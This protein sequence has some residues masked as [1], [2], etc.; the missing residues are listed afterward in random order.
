MESEGSL[1]P[2][3]WASTRSCPN[4]YESSPHLR[5]LFPWH[6]NLPWPHYLSDV[7]TGARRFWWFSGDVT[8][9]CGVRG[10]LVTIDGEQYL[11]VRH[12]IM[13]PEVGDLELYV[14]DLFTGSDELSEYRQLP[15]P[16]SLSM[17]CPPLLV[18]LICVHFLFILV[19][20]PLPPL[21]LF[22]SSFYSSALFLLIYLYFLPA[23]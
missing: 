5:T 19:L 13:L 23:P 11:K 8:A 10:D 4:P 22:Y 18:F 2:S 17:F 21:F 16:A 14:S 12:V 1:Q 7:D 3:K 9:T 15:Y 6:C 20:I